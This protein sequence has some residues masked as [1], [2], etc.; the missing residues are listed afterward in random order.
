MLSGTDENFPLHLWCR[1]IPQAEKQLAL[2]MQTN[3]NPK[4]STYAYLYGP[5]NYN[6]HPF[7]PVGMEAMIYDHP[8]KRRTFAQHCS[9]GYVL[10]TST[11]HYRCWN[12]WNVKTK[13]TRVSETVFF[14]HKYISNPTVT[15]ADAIISAA[16]RMTEALRT[17]KP[18]GMHE[19]DIQALARLEQI[20]QAA[21]KNNTDVDV[22]VVDPPSPRVPDRHSREQEQNLL[23]DAITAVQRPAPRVRET[24]FLP[25][26]DPE[27]PRVDADPARLVVAY[28]R[29]VV[30][31]EDASNT[32]TSIPTITQDDDERPQ[33]PEPRASTP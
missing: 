20:F 8:N 25:L 28:P 9:K 31:S 7:V 23:A 12:L 4:I 32:G 26:E 18:T 24:I 16:N 1:V 19:E 29:A 30:T 33:R 14:K 10:S 13:S 11:E 6:S 5:H 3:I 15:P 22:T 2:L 17:H 21:A 27:P